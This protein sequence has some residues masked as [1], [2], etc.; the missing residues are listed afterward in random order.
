V[1][2]S[3]YGHDRADDASSRDRCSSEPGPVRGLFTTSG[4]P[5]DQFGHTSRSPIVTG[6]FVR[7]GY[8]VDLNELLGSA[9]LFKA[10]R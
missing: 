9:P 2:C 6:G 1:F 4:R 7:A 10:V 8:G 5:R 3:L